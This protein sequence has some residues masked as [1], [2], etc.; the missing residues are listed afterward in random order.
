MDN[1]RFMDKFIASHSVPTAD[2]EYFESVPWLKRYLNDPHY[3]AIPTFSR[4]LKESG[5]DYFFSTTINTPQTIPYQITLL[6][7]DLKLPA[8]STELAPQSSHKIATKA[9]DYPDNLMLLRLGNPGLDGHPNTLHGGIICSILDE[10]MGLNV[11][12]HHSRIPK[13]TREALYTVELKTTYR[14]AI[15]TPS[16]VLVRCWLS[17]R[18]GRKWYSRGQIVNQDG[19]VMSE[20]EG[21]W[22]T[23]KLKEHKL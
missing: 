6:S 10:T 15:P 14:T 23:A 16:D 8:A 7:R 22:V 2:Q 3:Q 12:L 11:V 17:R 20:A 19:V 5:E 9:P 4:V 1:S 18:E 13:E 21:V